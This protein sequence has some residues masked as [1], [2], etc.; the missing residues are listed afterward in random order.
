M[1]RWL[2]TLSDVNIPG[3]N[4]NENQVVFD[5]NFKAEC[6]IFIQHVVLDNDCCI[7]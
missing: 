1:E 5:S 3:V 2:F 7:S 6:R 4:E